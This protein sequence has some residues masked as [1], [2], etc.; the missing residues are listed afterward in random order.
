M[1]LELEAE[2]RTLESNFVKQTQEHYNNTM[3][4]M[5]DGRNEDE[6]KRRHLKQQELNLALIT[7]KE[8]ERLALMN[9]LEA[10]NQQYLNMAEL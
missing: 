4:L 1:R 10:L 8:A 9:E 6:M 2:I 3:Y 5:K 7:K